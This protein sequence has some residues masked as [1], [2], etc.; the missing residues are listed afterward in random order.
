MNHHL[1][2]VVVRA[3]SRVT[4]GEVD[5]DTVPAPGKGG[6]MESIS[7]SPEDTREVIRPTPPPD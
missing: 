6:G 4:L 3:T 7:T 5:T 2:E 1:G